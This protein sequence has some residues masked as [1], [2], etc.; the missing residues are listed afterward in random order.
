MC[1][2]KEIDHAETINFND[3]AIKIVKEWKFQE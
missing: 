3:S 2:D 1:I